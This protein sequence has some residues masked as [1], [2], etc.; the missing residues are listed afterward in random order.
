MV[1]LSQAGLASLSLRQTNILWVA[2]IA[3]EALCLEMDKGKTQHKANFPVSNDL[4]R[5]SFGEYYHIC[6]NLSMAETCIRT[7]VSVWSAVVSLLAQVVSEP[8]R[9]LSI[10]LPYIP[11]AACFVAFLIWNGGIVLGDKSMHVA[12]LHVPQIYYF[13]GFTSAML[14]PY[15]FKR[16]V[17]VGTLST[18]FGTPA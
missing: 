8:F 6:Y 13:L 17:V 14:V 10:A 7:T 2:Y 15:L 9:V 1:Q 3:F 11:V 18:L 12:V 4:G 5:L 16:K